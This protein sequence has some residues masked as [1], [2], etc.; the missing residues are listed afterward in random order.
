MDQQPVHNG[1]EVW[2]LALGVSYIC[3]HIMTQARKH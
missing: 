3:I 1:K 2:G